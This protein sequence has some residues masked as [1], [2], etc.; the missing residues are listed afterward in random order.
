MKFRLYIIIALAMLFI[1]ICFAVEPEKT[2]ILE[3]GENSMAYTT[4]DSGLKYRITTSGEGDLC[5]AGDIVTVHY[6]GTLEDGSKFDSSYDRNEP[7]NFELGIGQVIKGWDEGIALLNRGAKATL[8][9]PPQLAYGD[10]S[11]GV[12]PANS[13][14]VFQV[15]LLDFKP[16]PVIEPYDISGKVSSKT[17]SGLEF[18]LVEKGTGLQAADG[19]TVSVHYTGYFDDGR[20][21]DSSIKRDQPFEFVLGMGQVISGWDEGIALMKE[22]DKARL[23]I[24]SELAY[25]AAG[26]GGVIPPNA[27]LTFDVELIKVK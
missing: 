12:I 8:I 26:A 4:T 20:I 10:R 16:A 18:I 7:I 5:Q 1:S 2:K 11:V 14:L 22:G 13:T 15:E 27:T 3:Q 23:I 6:T 19:N 25:G 24:P 9:I 17:E 21:F